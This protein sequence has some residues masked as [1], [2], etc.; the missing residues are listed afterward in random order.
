MVESSEEVKMS[1]EELKK[2]STFEANL[3]AFKKKNPDF[4]KRYGILVRKREEKAAA[5]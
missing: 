3:T 5:A 1:A 2:Q 4:E